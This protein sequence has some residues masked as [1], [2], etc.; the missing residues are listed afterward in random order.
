MFATVVHVSTKAEILEEVRK[1]VAELLSL[2]LEC[3]TSE[4]NLTRDLGVD[5]LNH[6]ELVMIFEETFGL[7]EIPE[8]DYEKTPTVGDIVE[9]LAKRLGIAS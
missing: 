2:P 4:K 6:A 9:Y 1:I 8:I 3:V 7:E 5:S